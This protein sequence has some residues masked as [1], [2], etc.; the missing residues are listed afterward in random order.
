MGLALEGLCLVRPV[1]RKQKAGE[2]RRQIAWRGRENMPRSAT[3]AHPKKTKRPSP[4]RAKST[5]PK[6]PQRTATK[7]AKPT[8][9]ERVTR[10]LPKRAV[11][12]APKKTGQ[13][14]VAAMQAEISALRT[15][16]QE[17]RD[18]QTA[19]AEVL[20]VI[21]S[22]TGDLAPVY[23]RIFISLLQFASVCV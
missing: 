7:K 2:P 12:A 9:P 19:T 3:K 13:T 11:R 1:R 22:S 14:S 8:A 6:K 20:Q 16:L 10:A 15:E 18:Q 4:N 17:A 23:S 5:A 21:N